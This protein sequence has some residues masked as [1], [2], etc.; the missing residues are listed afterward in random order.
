MNFILKYKNKNKNRIR[1]RIIYYLQP[2]RGIE[3]I[4]QLPRIH[5]QNVN[6]VKTIYI[7]L[8]N[9]Q[10]YMIVDI[11]KIHIIFFTIVCIKFKK[12]NAI[13]IQKI[14]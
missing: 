2:S 11:K 10:N 8:E 12:K 6:N 3:V 13:T 4:E 14:Y 9:F 5:L 1:I 7:S